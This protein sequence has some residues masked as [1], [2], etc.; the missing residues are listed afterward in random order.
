MKRTLTALLVI[1]MA[2][3]SPAL[4]D[5]PDEDVLRPRIGGRLGLFVEFDPGLNLTF[6]DGNPYVRP[7][8]TSYE[9][10]TAIYRSALGISPYLGIS[11]DTN[12]R[13]ISASHCMPPSTG[14]LLPIPG[15]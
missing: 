11:G 4:A 5:P 10:E 8:F 9:Q 2:A 3:A 12:F 14:V 6:L 1:L 15:R 13:P 7:L